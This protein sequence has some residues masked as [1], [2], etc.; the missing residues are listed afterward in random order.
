[1]DFLTK[2]KKLFIGLI[3]IMVNY[4]AQKA[5]RLYYEAE[6][7]EPNTL[8]RCVGCEKKFRAQR[9]T[10]HHHFPRVFFKS[11]WYDIINMVLV[12]KRCHHLIH[13]AGHLYINHIKKPKKKK[14]KKLDL[15]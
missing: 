4:N 13:L 5:R 11:Q 9:M 1:M 2:I 10:L 14:Y 3:K 12:C 7:L 8:V 15:K 6:S